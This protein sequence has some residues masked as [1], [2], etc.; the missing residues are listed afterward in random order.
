M[1]RS[2][3]GHFG[4]IQPRS[5]QTED[6]FSGCFISIRLLPSSSGDPLVCSWPCCLPELSYGAGL[7]QG[8]FGR[9]ACFTPEGP[10]YTKASLRQNRLT[11]D[12]LAAPCQ[13]GWATSTEHGC[14]WG[15]TEMQS[16]GK[17]GFFLEG[18]TLAWVLPEG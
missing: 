8:R 17:Q 15:K 1:L 5:I 9:L 3:G 2:S 16:T 4:P 18:E 10:L 6:T 14:T 7:S 13:N 11:F 12:L